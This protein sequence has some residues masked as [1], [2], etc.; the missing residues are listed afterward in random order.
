MNRL[1]D[2]D[3]TDIE[4]DA[5]DGSTMFRD[6]GEEVLDSHARRDPDAEARDLHDSGDVVQ[7][8]LLVARTVA[9][10]SHGDMTYDEARLRLLTAGVPEE[11]VES[12][13]TRLGNRFD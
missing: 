3:P 9:A 5:D 2:V 1:H 8:R 12:F 11:Q 7:N 13:V 10:V 4:L 6:V